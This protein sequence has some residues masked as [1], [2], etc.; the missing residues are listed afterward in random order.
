MTIINSTILLLLS[1]WRHSITKTYLKTWIGSTGCRFILFSSIFL[2]Y[3]I[4]YFSIFYIVDIFWFLNQ[5]VIPFG[6]ARSARAMFNGGRTSGPEVLILLD[7]CGRKVEMRSNITCY[8]ASIGYH[9]TPA[10]LDNNRALL[11]TYSP[12]IIH[13]AAGMLHLSPFLRVISL[14]YPLKPTPG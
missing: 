7:S 12:P 2:N 6:I 14:F 10:Y 13:P 4:I 3:N 11:L 8:D 1:R 5:F 9:R